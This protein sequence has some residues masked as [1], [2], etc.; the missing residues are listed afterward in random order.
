MAFHQAGDL[1]DLAFADIGRG[2]DVVERRDA[3]LD[4][5]EIDGAREPDRLV[6]PRRRR[7]L[8]LPPRVRDAA[9]PARRRR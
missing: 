4:D 7:A 2:P 8:V 1:V 5:V 6:E 9:A 3:G